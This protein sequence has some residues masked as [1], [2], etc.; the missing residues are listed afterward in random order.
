MSR[1]SRPLPAACRPIS[2][3]TKAARKHYIAAIAAGADPAETEALLAETYFGEAYAQIEGNGFT[4]AGRAKA[5][6]GLPHLRKAID[7]QVAKGTPPPLNWYERGF[8]TSVVALSPDAFDWA[9]LTLAQTDKASGLAHR[10]ALAAGNLQGHG[11]PG[12]YRPDAPHVRRQ[13]AGERL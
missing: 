4:A 12:Q 1:R 7:S 10:A 9:K 3:T 2:R 8:Q 5:I 11:A 6:E 13:G